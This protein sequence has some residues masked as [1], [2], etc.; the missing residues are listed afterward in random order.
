MN[1]SK[2]KT[3]TIDD[4]PVSAR[5][6]TTILQVAR[7]NGIFI[8][9]LC[10]LDGLSS[11]SACRLCLVE[12]KGLNK[13]VP[14]CVTQIFE[15]MQVVTESEELSKNRKMIL[16]LL[17]AER[18]HICSICVSNGQCELQSMAQK[19]GL[20]HVHVP[21]R[22]PVHEVDASHPRFIADNNRCILCTRCVRVCEE[23]EGANTWGVINRGEKCKV[24][25]DLNQPWGE[26]ETCTSC[27]KC[28][29]VC[30]TGALI[31][32]GRT[33]TDRYKKKEFLPYLTMMRKEQS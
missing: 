31:E 24:V 19:L 25:T 33:S 29:Q 21:Y 18:N 26:S 8:P 15:G 32:K 7:D 12:I 17:F 30:P 22:F 13:M 27:S 1:P 4:R 2:V 11:V 16:A 14:A 23:I 5:S 20:D 9:T 28:V 6:G 10:A 3:L